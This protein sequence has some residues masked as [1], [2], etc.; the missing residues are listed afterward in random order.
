MN[1]RIKKIFVCAGILSAVCGILLF[2][3]CIWPFG[4]TYT[5]TYDCL[6]SDAELYDD[7]AYLTGRRDCSMHLQTTKNSYGSETTIGTGSSGNESPD[8]I[9]KRLSEAGGLIW[10]DYAAGENWSERIEKTQFEMRKITVEPN[11]FL[12]TGK[13]SGAE[14]VYWGFYCRFFP[15]HR[16]M[17]G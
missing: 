7:L 13:I 8:D 2:G 12:N 4:L 11:F 16:G 10:R 9:L 14:K 17:F 3:L 5:L 1:R 6:L 15:W